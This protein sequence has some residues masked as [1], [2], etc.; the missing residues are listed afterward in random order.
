VGYAVS[1][2]ACGTPL[3]I[4][5]HRSH[6]TLLWVTIAVVSAVGAANALRLRAVFTAGGIQVQNAYRSYSVRWDVV[7]VIRVIPAP[8][9]CADF[10]WAANVIEV[11]PNDGERFPI[12][13]ATH[14]RR[15]TAERLGALVEQR[16]AEFGFEAPPSLV[17]LWKVGAV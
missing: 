7:K 17:A 3:A 10:G 16:A 11:E 2:L 13:V 6:H 1:T 9:N 12:R 8:W 5:V 14:L 4:V 15:S